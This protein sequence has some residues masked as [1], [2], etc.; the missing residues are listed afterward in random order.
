MAGVWEAAVLQVLGQGMN[1]VAMGESTGWLQVAAVVAGT[2]EAKT[3]VLVRKEAAVAVD[4]M[5]KVAMGRLVKVMMARAVQEAAIA[6]VVLGVAM[7][8]MLVVMGVVRLEQ[9]AL[10]VGTAGVGRLAMVVVGRAASEVAMEVAMLRSLLFQKGNVVRS[11]R[12]RVRAAMPKL[13]C[14]AAA[15]LLHVTRLQ[16]TQR[17]RWARAEATCLSH[18]LTSLSLASTL[19]SRELVKGSTTQRQP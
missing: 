16:T 4:M 2:A 3:V 9:A 19:L 18:A 14:T 1:R 15:L 6:M 5:M 8:A 12:V 7:L 17:R 10:V 13:R 11:A